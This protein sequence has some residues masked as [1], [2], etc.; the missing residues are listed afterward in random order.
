M[1]IGALHIQSAR[2]EKAQPLAWWITTAAPLATAAVAFTWFLSTQ[3]NR[4]NS[5]SAPSW[6]LGQTQQLLWSLANGYGWTSSFEYGHNFLGIHLEPILLPIALV[7]HI[8]PTPVVP[9]V[10][11]AAGLAA[12]APAAFLMFRAL[13][14]EKPSSTWL[15][16]AISIPIPFWAATQAAASSQF[17]PENLALAL[18]MLAVWAG[19]RAKPWL[20]WTLAVLVLS[21]KEDQTYTAFVIGLVVWRVGP[22]PMRAHG[23][24]VMILAGAW[25]LVGVGMFQELIRGTGYSPDVAY[26]WWVV[27]PAEP[28]FFLR[29]LERP[30][31]WLVLSGLLLSVAGLPFLAPRWLL[32]VI[33][34]LFANLMSSHDAQ[35]RLNQHYVMVVMFPVIIAAAFGARRL[36]TMPSVQARLRPNALL[37]AAVPA[38]AIG[39]FAG[40]LPPAFGADTWLFTRPPAADRLLLATRVIPPNAPVY[41]DDG[42]AVWLASRQFI[43]VLPSQ[44][45]PER[46]V[47]VDRQDWDHRQQ[48]SVARADEIAVLQVSGR[49]LLV[50][51]GRFQ[52]WSPVGG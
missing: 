38:L 19:L 45:P 33:P 48:E 23:R 12:T 47:V 24:R 43:Q 10:F 31:A 29:N 5:I 50:D 4:L 3:L 39:L 11:A 40:Q 35:G 46:Y 27:N 18:A 49:R 21:C 37:G 8:L 25:L 36:L 13:L 41:A 9:L 26:Y 52:V 1:T 16:L 51:D 17:H 44:P 2:R 22:P 6:D 15:A 42:A 7:E 14:P 20:L 28:N 34:P 30:D 32:L